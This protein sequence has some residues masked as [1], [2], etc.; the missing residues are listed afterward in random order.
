[1]ILQQ[2]PD[3]SD[4]TIMNCYYQYGLKDPVSGKRKPDYLTMV[5]KDNTT[6]KKKYEIIEQG[7]Q[8]KPTFFKRITLNN[9]Y[10]RAD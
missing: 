1:M 9:G 4:L 5:Y 10:V 7:K 6:G 3:G 8:V 2:Y